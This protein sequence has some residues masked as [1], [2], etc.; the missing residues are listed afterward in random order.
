MSGSARASDELDLD[1]SVVGRR[2]RQGEGI[3]SLPIKAKPHTERSQ[4]G[5]QIEF[6]LTCIGYS[7]G[8]GNI[9]RFPY[10][11]M[12][13]GGGAF[14]VPY[15]LSLAI[16]GIS[17]FLMETAIGQS[18]G[19]S[20]IRIFNMIPFFKGLGWCMV[21]ASGILSI[22]YNI[23]IAYVLY[24]LV[25]SFNWDLPWST[26]GN[27]WNTH[28]CFTYK[29][30]NFTRTEMS[31]ETSSSGHRASAAEEFWRF[32]VL[33]VSPNIETIGGI[34][35]KLLLAMI[36]AWALT[37]I[38]MCR[39]IRSSGKVVYFTATAPYVLLTVILIRGITLEGSWTGLEFYIFPN[40]TQLRN[41]EVWIAAATQIFYSLGPAWGGLITFASY[42]RFQHNVMRDAI[43][44]P[45][46]CALTSIYGGFAIFSVIGHLMHVTG[47][48]DTTELVRQGPGLAF[49]AYPQALTQLPGAVFWS[50]LFFVTLLTL[51]LDSQFA[52]LEAVTTGL[53]DRFPST[54]GQHHAL[55]TLAVCLIE[56]VLGLILVTR[57][58]FYYFEL[59]D[60]Y[61]TAFSVVVI[62]FLESLVISYLYGAQ[63]LLHDVECMVGKLR[64]STHIWWLVN[65][66]VLVPM[67][68]FAIIVST[69][70]N[71]AQAAASERKRFP[72]WAIISGW[73]IACLSFIPFP[74]MAAF[75][76]WHHGLNWKKLFVPSDEWQKL[77]DTRKA[78]INVALVEEDLSNGNRHHALAFQPES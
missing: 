32:N 25:M 7:V 74:I 43:I 75:T 4:W 2:K 61:A 56:F 27:A 29:H 16:C 34:H 62:G 55:V 72:I 33:E 50:V 14:L 65:W 10:L 77:V 73:I 76:T 58:G 37:F 6:V 12:R 63:R 70:V 21:S 38:C 60:N 51:G 13:Y 30:E 24:F 47:Q 3:S 15:L 26:C 1:P 59:F 35:W 54:V 71:H 19:L 23:L 64:R 8:L 17:L 49:I 52:T 31:N 28:N 40:W 46:V 41:I 42:N 48:R 5:K 9:W 68:T 66:Y 53:T 39:G 78:A 45:V 11:C 57:A 20:T 44:I 18:T 67:M 69:F 36:A 22:Y